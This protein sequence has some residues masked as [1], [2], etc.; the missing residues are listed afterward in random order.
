MLRNKLLIHNNL[1]AYEVKNYAEITKLLEVLQKSKSLSYKNL[2][3]NLL[4]QTLDNNKKVFFA[5]DFITENIYLDQQN[6]NAEKVLEMLNFLFVQFNLPKIKNLKEFEPTKEF[7]KFNS[8]FLGLIPPI[9]IKKNYNNNTYN[10]FD[11][12]NRVALS[13][14]MLKNKTI[15]TF[16]IE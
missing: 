6:I 16:I 13:I 2:K 15:P 11:G 14:F 9:I 12:N 3:I 10:I 5:K 4:K 1:K 7:N 8:Q